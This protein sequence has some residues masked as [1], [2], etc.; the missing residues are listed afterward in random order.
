[1]ILETKECGGLTEKKGKREWCV[2]GEMEKSVCVRLE[3]A[4]L[5]RRK[6]K[7]CLDASR[8]FRR[9]FVVKLTTARLIN[10]QKLGSLQ[11]EFVYFDSSISLDRCY[12][13]A[14]L[15]T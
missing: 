1:V 6:V 7:Q 8:A 11:D 4:C 2:E 15:C 14:D 3:S 10:S 12:G 9:W 13:E 5:F